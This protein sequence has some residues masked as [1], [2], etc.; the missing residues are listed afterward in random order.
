MCEAGAENESDKT[1]KEHDVKSVDL[2]KA[3]ADESW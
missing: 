1:S 3:T 2:E